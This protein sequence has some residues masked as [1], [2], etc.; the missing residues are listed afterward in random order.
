VSAADRGAKPLGTT[1]AKLLP[2]LSTAEREALAASIAAEGVLVPI[3]VDEDGE[4]IEGGHRYERGQREGAS[5]ASITE[6]KDK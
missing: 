1:Y 3:L 5:D 2:P 4:I 6:G